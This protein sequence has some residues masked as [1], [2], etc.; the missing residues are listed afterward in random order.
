MIS[1]EER[2]SIAINILAHCRE[3]EMRGE[4]HSPN[5][6]TILG[7]LVAPDWFVEECGAASICMLLQ[8]PARTKDELWQILRSDVERFFPGQ[9]DWEGQKRNGTPKEIAEKLF[10]MNP[11]L[12]ATM[13][14]EIKGARIAMQAEGLSTE[15]HH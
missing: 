3:R 9:F 5:Y 4:P 12:K 15:R 8:I 14:A 7:I 1:Q 2:F 6:E 11:D 13:R 10:E